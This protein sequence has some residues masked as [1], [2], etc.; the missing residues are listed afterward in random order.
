MSCQHPK[1]S[2]DARARKPNR[3]TIKPNRSPL[4]HFP[5]SFVSCSF[6]QSLATGNVGQSNQ[7]KSD[8]HRNKNYIQHKSPPIYFSYQIETPENPTRIS[9]SNG[10]LLVHLCLLQPQIS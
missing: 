9:I 8:D 4:K 5:N 1:I 6:P 7:E 2:Q 10:I 3:S